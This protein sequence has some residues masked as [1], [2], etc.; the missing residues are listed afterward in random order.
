MA[1]ST[2]S[3]AW[4]DSEDSDPGHSEHSEL[5]FQSAG[6]RPRR[7]PPP[8]APNS[9]SSF[10]SPALTRSASAGEPLFRSEAAVSPSFERPSKSMALPD[11]AQFPI[12]Y[13]FHPPNHHMHSSPPG[14]SSADSSSASTRSSAYTSFGSA[15]ASSDDPHVHVAGSEYDESTMGLGITS[16]SVVQLLTN[17]P[18]SSSAH[19]YPSRTPLDQTSSTGYSGTRSRSSSL[20][21]TNA[22]TIHGQEPTHRLRNQPSYDMSW[23]RVDERDEAGISEDETDEDHLLNDDEYGI[24]E[25]RTSAAVVAEEGRGQIVQGHSLPVSQL[26]VQPGTTHLIVGSSSTPNSMPS[27]LTNIIPQIHATLLA[28]DISANFLGAIPPALEACVQLEELNI[29]SN[30]LRVLPSFLSKLQNLRVLMADSTGIT[31]LSETL[32]DLDKLHTISVRKNKMHALPSWL[33]LLPALQELF[34]DGNPF[35]GPWKALVEPLLAKVPT[36]PV[37]PLST[38]TFPLPSATTHASDSDSTDIEEFSEPPSALADVN[39]FNMDEDHTITP[40]RA[41]MLSH[42]GTSSQTSPSPNPHQSRPL[43]RNR[44]TPNRAFYNQSRGKSVVEGDQEDMKSPKLPTVDSPR[45]TDSGYFGDHEIRKMKSAG[46]LRRNQTSIPAPGDSPVPALTRPPLK[47]SATTTNPTLPDSDTQSSPPRPA[48]G[49]RYASI[50]PSGILEESSK[51]YNRPALTQLMWESSPDG[52]SSAANSPDSSR[53]SSYARSEATTQSPTPTPIE[54]AYSGDHKATIRPRTK[55]GKEK[56]RWGFL[57]KMSMGKM[58][59]DT[60]QRVPYT[61]PIP[62]P[63]RPPGSDSPQIDMRISTTGALSTFTLSASNDIP[64]PT[65]VQSP[66]DT[67]DEY[68]SNEGSRVNI[69]PL[70][71]N[72]FTNSNSISSTLLHPPSPTP[73]SGK[74]RSFLPIE[75]HSLNIPIPENAAFVPGMTAMNG[76]DQQSFE[77]RDRTPSPAIETDQ[78]L[79]REQER[80]R[81]AYTR[82]LRS[83]MAYLRDMNDLSLSQQAAQVAVYGIA[84]E[85]ILSHRPRALTTTMDGRE[86]S[87]SLGDTSSYLRSCND[88]TIGRVRSGT[89]SQTVSVAA[90][91]SSQSSDDR[92]IK[93]DKTKRAMVAKEILVTERTFVKGL[94]QLI[95]IYVKPAC[96]NVTI[97]SGVS[98]SK[99]TVVPA[100]ERKI[101]FGGLDALFSFHKE[102]FL[103]SLEVALKPLMVPSFE[104]EDADGQLSLS[105]ANAVGDIFFKHAA[106]MK[107][108]SSYINNFENAVQRVKYWTSDRHTAPSLSPSPSMSPSSSTAHLV[109]LGLSMSS[110]SNPGISGDGAAATGV[111][112]LT[113]SQRKRIRSYLKRC[114]MHP[115]HSQLNLEGYLLLPVQRIPRYKLLLEELRRSAPPPYG[116]MEDPLDRALAEISSLANNMNEGKRES[117]SR[118]K[119]VVWQSRIRGKFPSPLVQPHR[120]LIMDGPLLLTRVVRKAI[121]TFENINAQGDASTVDVDCLAPEL[122]PRPLIG[123]LCN[124]LLVLCRDPSE[125]RD[126]SS[127]V[128]LWAVLRMQTLPQPASIVHGNALRLVDNKAILYFDAPSALDAL[129]WYRAINLHIPTSKT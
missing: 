109:G 19:C 64:V 112:N 120:R 8:A 102:S 99:E 23:Q 29:G 33:C 61:S 72:H 118:R 105:V 78:Y 16:D 86:L 6:A 5:T 55:D 69:S 123:I 126:P 51:S 38:P 42:D 110:I 53:S 14:L 82:A 98:S 7:P 111:P 17:D 94:Q 35:Q 85:P 27:F 50:G 11:P 15:L 67:E 4:I 121:V 119:L 25:E 12:P 22:N 46:D 48:L 89:S 63:Q 80:V 71:S 24:E 77:N 113:S 30:P 73:R 104:K 101:V 97:L 81:E 58:K 76:D 36:T 128:D 52:N 93:D 129:N 107:M 59:P 2:S 115:Q 83:V 114:R 65:V 41:P 95:D 3:S 91:D 90:S 10:R 60:S 18:T 88:Q 43:T 9:S 79:R 125:G 108:Y 117:E 96:A 68:E 116:Y 103:P 31:T 106:F 127:Y 49:K 26:Q 56:T 62:R 39:R 28:L 44:T 87:L 75:G 100:S 74:R 84:G 13:P 32:A 57:K 54:P 20:A 92:K 66:P 37:Y 70:A 40:D 124:D 122:T 21:N 47:Q 1:S 34:V 45:S